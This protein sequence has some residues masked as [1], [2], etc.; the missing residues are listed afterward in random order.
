MFRN[1]FQ[2]SVISLF[3]STGSQPLGLWRSEVDVGLPKDS[4]ITLISDSADPKELS[5]ALDYVSLEEGEAMSKTLVHPILH[6]Q[7]PTLNST[8]IRCPSSSNDSLGI[9][10]PWLHIQFRN[11]YKPWAFEVGISDSSRHQGAIRYSTFQEEAALLPGAVPLLILPLKLPPKTVS[12]LTS[13]CT[14]SVDLR[15]LASH[16]RSSELITRPSD[17]VNGSG[18]Y[19]STVPAIRFSEVVYVKVYANCRLRRLWFSEEKE[20][21]GVRRPWE[22]E[23]YG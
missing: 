19:N 21:E 11:L 3:S 8:F 10:L 7:S 16:F 20:R 6:I 12:S 15:V 17:E 4:H 18:S 23:L 22:L 1:Q 14:L 2:S 5:D 13:W 9:M